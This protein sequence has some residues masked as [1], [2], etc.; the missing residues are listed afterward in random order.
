MDS[1]GRE[2]RHWWLLGCHGDVVTVVLGLKCSSLKNYSKFVSNSE[3]H[4]FI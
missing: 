1:G 2:G 3:S 4:D